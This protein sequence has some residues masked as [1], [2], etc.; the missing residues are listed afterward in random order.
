MEVTTEVHKQY[1]SVDAWAAQLGNVVRSLLWA[2]GTW[3]AL[4]VLLV[5]AQFIGAI[6]FSDWVPANEA[7]FKEAANFVATVSG[8][9][10]AFAV[11]IFGLP[12]PFRLKN[13]FRMEA[14]RRVERYQSA[15]KQV[16]SQI[17][18]TDSL[19]ISY[20]L[21]SKEDIEKR[22]KVRTETQ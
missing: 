6:L 2:T 12:L 14:E 22:P 20:G 19:L 18:I 15:K 8:G 13:V 9:V 10:A 17:E 3:L 5:G 11:L 7:E 1:R 16:A 4:S 21:I